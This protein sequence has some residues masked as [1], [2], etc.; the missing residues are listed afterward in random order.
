MMKIIAIQIQPDRLPAFDEAAFIEWIEGISSA[1]E[2]IHSFEWVSGFDD[3]RYLNL[4]FESDRIPELWSKFRVML[5]DDVRFGQA[6]TVA[7]IAT[8][9]GERGWDDYWLLYHFDPTQTLDIF[10]E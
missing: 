6:L 10:N 5:Y 9:Q 2:L 3:G 1:E 7:S 8:C 4:K